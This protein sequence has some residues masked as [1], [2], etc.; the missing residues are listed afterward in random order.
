VTARGTG[1]G[2]VCALCAGLLSGCQKLSAVVPGSDATAARAIELASH[3][4]CVSCHDI[5]GAAV[6]G[7]V[8]PALRGINGRA[9]LAGGLPNTP[10]QIVA[11]IRFPERA[12]PGT[13]M[14]NL[15][16]SESDARELA[17]FLYTLR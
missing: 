13:L 15:R 3:H 4:G 6:T 2:L 9:Y 17:T 12:R 14:P 8:G 5:P 7:R 16:V 11:F 10:E 1:L